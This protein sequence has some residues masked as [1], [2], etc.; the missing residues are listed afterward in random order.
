MW[1]ASYHVTEETSRFILSTTFARG[2]GGLP[3]PILLEA[4]PR[5]AVPPNHGKDSATVRLNFSGTLPRIA[6]HIYAE[7]VR[8]LTLSPFSDGCELE[9]GRF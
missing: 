7:A 6:A 9:F 8:S 3:K 4:D 2:Q 1:S 5:S